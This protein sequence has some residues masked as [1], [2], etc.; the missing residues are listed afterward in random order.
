MPAVFNVVEEGGTISTIAQLLHK[1]YNTV[2]NWVARF[3]EFG[4]SG[5]YEKP[6][7]GRPTKTVNHKITE[8]VQ[9]LKTVF[10]QS[11]LCTK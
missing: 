9:V 6:R 10:F 8:F 7:S 3:K 5:L 2:K 1:S 11:I 4:T